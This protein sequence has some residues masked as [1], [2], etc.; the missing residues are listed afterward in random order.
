[1]KTSMRRT[2]ATASALIGVALPAKGQSQNRAAF[3][4][5]PWMH[6][7]PMAP[8]P[9]G[10]SSIP[11][12]SP[13]LCDAKNGPFENTFKSG[14]ECSRS[15]LQLCTQGRLTGDLDA[16]YD[17]FFTTMTV[18]DPSQPNT[19]NFTG[20][21]EIT[22]A[23]GD[24][25]TGNDSGII[26]LEQ[27]GFSTFQTNVNFTGGTGSLNGASNSITAIG[28]VDSATGQ[29][30]GIYTGTLCVPESGNVCTGP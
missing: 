27:T 8:P 20:F 26:R 3:P 1:M 11:S 23:S 2:I 18:A 9:P 14:A 15:P 10:V 4:E 22:L 13:N 24:K 16:Q 6:H 5:I 29:G 7:A 21:S 25:I 30:R 19:F 28:Q 12:T 17:F